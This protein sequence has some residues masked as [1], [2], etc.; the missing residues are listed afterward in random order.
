MGWD[1]CDTVAPRGDSFVLGSTTKFPRTSSQNDHCATEALWYSGSLAL[2]VWCHQEHLSNLE[3]TWI[4][5]TNVHKAHASLLRLFSSASSPPS[6]LRL[7]TGA[8]PIVRSLCG[9]SNSTLALSA[10]IRPISVEHATHLHARAA[11]LVVELRAS[12][13]APSDHSDLAQARALP[14]QV[15]D[16]YADALA[17]LHVAA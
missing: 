10:V 7:P 15:S 17:P 12:H 2:A 13:S 11:I 6:L 5:S 3:C 16:E 4:S 1:A 8:F 9:G 14:R